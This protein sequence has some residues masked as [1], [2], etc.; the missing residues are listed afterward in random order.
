MFELLLLAIHYKMYLCDLPEFCP[1]NLY[2]FTLYITF[3]YLQMVHLSKDPK[4]KTV[5]DSSIADA[6]HTKTGSK[7]KVT[8]QLGDAASLKQR[9]SE[10][11]LS[12]V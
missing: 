9:I 11:K 4:D 1:K 10:M 3:N 7:A 6:H 12:E 8:D 2:I 5:L